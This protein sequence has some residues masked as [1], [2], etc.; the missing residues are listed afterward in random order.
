MVAE[1]QSMCV[2]IS[3]SAAF[4]SIPLWCS[5]RSKLRSITPKPCHWNCDGSDLLHPFT[6]SLRKERQKETVLDSHTS[7]T[8]FCWP[9]SNVRPVTGRRRDLS[10]LGVRRR[11]VNCLHSSPGASSFILFSLWRKVFELGKG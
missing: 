7:C 11:K 6:I 1:A 4:A 2:N 3:S 5:Q 8:V 10:R 9:V